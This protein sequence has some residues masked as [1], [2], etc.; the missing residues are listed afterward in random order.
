[1]LSTEPDKRAAILPV[2]FFVRLTIAPRVSLQA[3]T[4]KSLTGCANFFVARNPCR[5]QAR[6]CASSSHRSLSS[7]S[8]SSSSSIAGSSS[9]VVA[10]DVMVVLVLEGSSRGWC[11]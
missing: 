3:L 2:G 9:I 11:V 7:S 6:I 5:G 4:L 10:A 8:S 1:M